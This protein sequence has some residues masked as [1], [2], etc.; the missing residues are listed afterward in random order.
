VNPEAEPPRNKGGRPRKP[1]AP[2]SAK[3][4]DLLAAIELT[5]EARDTAA[6][7]YALSATVEA[8]LRLLRAELAVSSAWAAYCRAQGNATHALGYGALAC[9]LAVQIG[10]LREIEAV[11]R[12]EKY[13]A[14]NEREDA[15]ARKRG[16][17]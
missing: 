2:R 5:E 14:R 16:G 3:Q 15:L 4:E 8:E 6:T 7:E 13:T 1:T 12:L 9:K 11:D 17:K 10:N